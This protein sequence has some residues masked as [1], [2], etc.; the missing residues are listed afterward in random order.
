[1]LSDRFYSSAE[2]RAL[3]EIAISRDGGCTLRHLPEAYEPCLGNLHVHHLDPPDGD[4]DPRALDLSNTSTVCAS[5]HS[6]WEAFI[7]R[8]VPAAG[9]VRRAR[10]TRRRPAS[11]LSS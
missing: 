3:R 4:D 2:W 1:M 9:T 11:A 7:R 5:H 8:G 6:R 10:R